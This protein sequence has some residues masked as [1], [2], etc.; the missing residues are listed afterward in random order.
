M[1]QTEKDL[2]T[3]HERYLQK[4]YNFSIEFDVKNIYNLAKK[5]C[6]ITSDN[7]IHY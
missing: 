1:N 2:V 4:D 5:V 6:F 3:I 7:N